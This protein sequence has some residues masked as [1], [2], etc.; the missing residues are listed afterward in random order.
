MNQARIWLVVNPTVGLPL[1]LGSVTTIALLV[2]YSVLSHT[3][4]FSGYWQGGKSVRAAVDTAPLPQVGEFVLPNG[5]KVKFTVEDTAPRQLETSASPVV[6]AANVAVDSPQLV[7]SKS[8]PLE[9]SDSTETA[10][11][12]TK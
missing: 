2:H 9:A 6:Y 12:T 4:W 11:T 10:S 8:P 1:F 7:V 3:T 5:A